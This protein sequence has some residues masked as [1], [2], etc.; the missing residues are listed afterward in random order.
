MPLI[1][2]SV[3]EWLILAPAGIPQAYALILFLRERLD[4]FLPA[5]LTTETWR[6]L[7]VENVQPVDISEIGEAAKMDLCKPPLTKGE[8][9]RMEAGHHRQDSVG[10]RGYAVVTVMKRATRQAVFA[11]PIYIMA[12]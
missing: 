1:Q 5:I 3:C 12:L 7:Y 8:K 2:K 9:A 10:K 11:V 4:N 6:S